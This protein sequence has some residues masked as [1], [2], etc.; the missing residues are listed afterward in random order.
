VDGANWDVED[1][2]PI[3]AAADELGAVLFMHPTASRIKEATPRYH[4]RNY[5]G[6]PLE[7]TIA[8][9][10]F[11]FGGILD[12]F[13]ELKLIAAHGGGFACWGIP[14]MD[15]GYSVRPEAREHIDKLPSE[16]LKRV[17]FDSL[18]HDFDN[19][20][21]IIDRVGAGQVVLGTDYPADMGQEDPVTWIRGSGLDEQTQDRVL[22][23]NLRRMLGK[24]GDILQGGSSGGAG[25]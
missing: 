3:F 23:Q 15:H 7:T 11:V 18:T 17:Y 14:R 21:F 5:I 6:N 19:L 9:A 12:Q 24:T 1:Y 8:L 20:Q 10:S 22:D 2:R 13:P 4:M 16:Y 25:L